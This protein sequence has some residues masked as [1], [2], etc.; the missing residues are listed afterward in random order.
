MN[1]NDRAGPRA[2]LP[3]VRCAVYTRKSTE[4]GLEQEFNSL[5][6]QREV[7]RGLRPQPGRTGLGA[8]ARPLRRR[9]LH[10]RQHG[11]ARP[12]TPQG[13]HPGRQ[14]RLRGRLQGRSPQPLP[15]RLRTPHGDLRAAPGRL[16]VRD[17]T[18][19]HG[20]QHG[21][22]DPQRAAVLRP[23]RARDHRRAHPRQDRRH[24]PQGQVGRRPAA[25]GLRRGPARRP[26]AGQRRRGRARPRHLRAVP[27]ARGAAAGG[28]GAGAARLGQQVL[29]DQEGPAVRRP[30]LHQD[31]PAPPA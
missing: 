6:A 24:A 1:S 18:V 27:G 13:R 11:P 25:A 5:D 3:L 16:R 28:A 29:A 4:E 17:A 2:T 12:A 23:V 9:R 10:R 21:P 22:A 19:Q 20:L 30:A 31:R 15:A 14:G 8:A 26:A 7:G